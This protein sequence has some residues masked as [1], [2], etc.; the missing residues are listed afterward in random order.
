[1]LM[2]E[3]WFFLPMHVKNYRSAN[4]SACNQGLLVIRS[5]PW[6]RT[7]LDEVRGVKG[8]EAKVRV[9]KGW[10][11]KPLGGARGQVAWGWAA[12]EPRA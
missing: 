1:M 5:S 3:T 11:G 8:I 7:G 4:L 2:G 12:R 10:G 6:K 9:A